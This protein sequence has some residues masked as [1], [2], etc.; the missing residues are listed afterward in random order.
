MLIIKFDCVVGNDLTVLIAQLVY[1]IDCV[2]PFEKAFFHLF[3][4]DFHTVQGENDLIGQVLL[5]RVKY[6]DKGVSL[7]ISL[8]WL[9]DHIEVEL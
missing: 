1:I 2:H 9:K 8:A 4:S 6:S 7:I 3:N 5:L